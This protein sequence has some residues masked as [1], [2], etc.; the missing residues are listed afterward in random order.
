MN[1]NFSLIGTGHCFGSRVVSNEETSLALGR[2]A[3]FLQ[4]RTGI[5]E[6][7]LPADGETVTSLSANAIRR[8][9]DDAGL[10][11]STLGN[12]TVLLHVQA[13]RDHLFPQSGV[14]V[15]GTLGLD[16]VRVLSVE[17]GC[18]EIMSSLDIALALLETGRCERVILCGAGDISDQIDPRDEDT[19]GLFGSGAAAVILST[20]GAGG[21]NCRLRALRWETHNQL[22]R[23]GHTWRTGGSR[24]EN[25]FAVE[26]DHYR[27]AGT[28]QLEAGSE[29]LPRLLDQVL[30]DAGWKAGDVDLGITHQPSRRI[31][32]MMV[33]FCGIDPAVVPP[34]VHLL[35]NM[36]PANILSGLTLGR[37]SGRLTP[38]AKVV[39]FAFGLGFTAGAAAIDILR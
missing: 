12:E 23:L 28:A 33:R 22:W 35:G 38:G 11:L 4:Q 32:D 6:R 37:E 7:R 10:E 3:N 24:R 36:G 1:I 8:A 21:T 29:L 19:A 30:D 25:G 9:C 26:Y 13:G 15:G 2:P 27:M 16:S 18:A 34:H 31:I 5:I 39:M 17:A 14:V 20:P